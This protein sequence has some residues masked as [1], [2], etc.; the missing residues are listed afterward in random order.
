MTT[1]PDRLFDD[2]PPRPLDDL[3]RASNLLE[4]DRSMALSAAADNLMAKALQRLE[5]GEVERARAL[6]DRALSLPD[7][8]REGMVP[9]LL[10]GTMLLFTAIS[11]DLESAPGDDEAW[12]DRAETLIGRRPREASEIRSHLRAL[13]N[14]AYELTPSEGRRLRALTRG[15][16]LDVAPL[17]EVPADIAARAT[18]IVGILEAVIEH[19]RLVEG[20]ADAG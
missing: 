4:S 16:P 11:D 8:D 14:D 18:A 12:L 1:S 20:S 7:D 6:V 2:G 17:A 10:A 5:A 9:A 15:V 3:A 13:L 19:R